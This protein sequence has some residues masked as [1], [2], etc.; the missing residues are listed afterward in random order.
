MSTA[1]SLASAISMASVKRLPHAAESEEGVISSMIRGGDLALAVAY[2]RIG[3]NAAL[4]FSEPRNA[5]VYD[6]LIADWQGG[7][8][9]DEILFT[10]RLRDEKKLSELG[11]EAR[12][13]HLRW[14]VPTAANLPNYLDTL[15]DKRWLRTAVRIGTKIV[16]RA[17]QDEH[18]V[19]G[20]LRDVELALFELSERLQV[21]AKSR[22]IKE[23]VRAVIDNLGDSEKILGISTGFPKLDALVG[24]LAP[25]A[26]IVLAGKISGGKSAFA[27]QM[28]NSLA[29]T[30]SIPTAIFTF[31]MS[32]EQTVQRIIQ[33]RSEVSTR[34]VVTGTAEMFEMNNYS[35]AAVEVAGA[36]LHVIAERLDIAGIRARCL[37]LK[38]RVALIDYLQIVPE[39]KQRGENNTDKLDRMSAETKQ[40]A[41]SLG[42]TIIEISQLTE[43]DGGFVTRGSKGITADSDQL[44]IIEGDDDE[45][46]QTVPKDLVVAKQRDGARA[47]IPFTFVRA[48]TKFREKK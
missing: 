11:G 27:E 39:A 36:P 3:T 37:Q 6:E 45:E 38:P 2:E 43:K 32:A 14:F 21:S 40:I 7:R 33:I 30:R 19:E 1:R 46:K 13:N 47:K 22:S 4:W 42:M 17:E 35:T 9:F 31:E 34:S 16:E 41:H 25:A 15:A 28:A 18:D 12:I 29:V 26:K 5:I 23:I 24:G 20:Q 10:Q 48:I 44:W 8:K